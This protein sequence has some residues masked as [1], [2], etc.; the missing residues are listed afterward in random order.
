MDISEFQEEDDILSTPVQIPKIQQN[1]HKIESTHQIDRPPTVT[2]ANPAT[3]PL[4]IR[5]QRIS[6][7]KQD[8]HLQVG[9]VSVKQLRLK[10]LQ[11]IFQKYQASE[12]GSPYMK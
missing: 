10:K 7:K 9:F 12:T 4:T 1:G 5:T 3:D 8:S 11:N 2:T 6:S